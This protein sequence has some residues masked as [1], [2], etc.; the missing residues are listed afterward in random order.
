[1]TTALL[2]ELRGDCAQCAALCCLAPAFDKSPCFGFDKPAATPCS[3]LAACGACRIHESRAQSGF[4]GCVSYDCFGAGQRVTQEVFGGRKWMS[5][6]NLKGPMTRAFLAM[7]RLHEMLS[8]LKTAEALPL[9]PAERRALS[10]FTIMLAPSIGWTEDTLDAAPLDEM[11]RQV[12]AFLQS[13]KRHVV[14][15]KSAK[16]TP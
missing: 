6:P 8:L 4:S 1:M 5:E 10:D 15:N 16:I 2:M 14:R 3:N 7:R 13:L 9:D 11:E 12:Q